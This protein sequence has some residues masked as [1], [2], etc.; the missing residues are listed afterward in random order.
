MRHTPKDGLG[1]SAKLH[2]LSD[3]LSD[4]FNIGSAKAKPQARRRIIAVMPDG[5][6]RTIYKSKYSGWNLPSGNCFTSHLASAKRE[7]VAA[8]ATIKTITE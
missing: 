1:D 5:T 6:E 4:I 3:C 2:M 8:G 7:W